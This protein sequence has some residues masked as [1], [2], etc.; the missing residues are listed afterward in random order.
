[1]RTMGGGENGICWVLVSD[2]GDRCSFIQ[3]ISVPP[4]KAKLTGDAPFLNHFRML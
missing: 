2:R 1:M 4:S 3:C